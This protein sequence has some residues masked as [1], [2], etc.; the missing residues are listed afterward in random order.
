MDQRTRNRVA[1]RIR[2]SIEDRIR[3]EALDRV[4]HLDVEII[5]GQ[6]E[7]RQEARLEHDAKR[8]GRRLFR[9]EVPIAADEAVIL[10]GRIR[11]DRLTN[12]KP[13]STTASVRGRGRD[14][15]TGAR[16]GGP[17]EADDLR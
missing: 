1:R 9:V 3:A 14:C 7:T 13:L 10:S 5:G 8:L 4:G 15:T 6:S 11:G 16:I 2:A 17:I 12:P